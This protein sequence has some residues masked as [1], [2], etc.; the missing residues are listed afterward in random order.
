MYLQFILRNFS[1]RA[2][3]SSEVDDTTLDWRSAGNT[4]GW[5]LSCLD[6]PSESWRWDEEGCKWERGGNGK[7]LLAQSGVR[8]Q[9]NVLDDER[10]RTGITVYLEICDAAKTCLIS[11]RKCTGVSHALVHTPMFSTLQDNSRL[12]CFHIS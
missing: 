7:A 10:C 2:S 8:N 12:R 9:P 1:V 3:S 11:S 6:G 4:G 5:T